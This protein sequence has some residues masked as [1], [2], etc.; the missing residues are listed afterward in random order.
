MVADT[1]KLLQSQDWNDYEYLNIDYAAC[2]DVTRLR[3]YYFTEME[4]QGALQ[5]PFEHAAAIAFLMDRGAF[6]PKDINLMID[7]TRPRK[8]PKDLKIYMEPHHGSIHQQPKGFVAQEARYEHSLNYAS[9]IHG[10]HAFELFRQTEQYDELVHH[11]DILKVSAKTAPYS[12]KAVAYF[13]PMAEF[14][15]L[16]RVVVRRDW[17]G[18]TE[19]I[20]P[21]VHYDPRDLD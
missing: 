15:W 11:R 5:T 4:R 18:W 8:D 1:H 14:P 12:E 17:G 21:T 3:R 13:R 2:M 6:K 7:L 10:Y 16:A 19:V 20:Y 9:A